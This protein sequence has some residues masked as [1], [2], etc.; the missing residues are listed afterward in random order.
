MIDLNGKRVLVTGGAGFVG[1]HLCE[2]LI[3]LGYVLSTGGTDNHLLLVNL[4]DKNITGNKVELICELV[5]I[6]LNKNAVLGDKSALTPG[7]IRIGT[8][9]LTTRG[10]LEKDFIE[11]ANLLD[12]TIKL[13]I[14]IQKKSGKKLIDFKKT[15]TEEY[16]NKEIN[17]IKKEVNT[18]AN[19]FEF[20]DDVVFLISSILSLLFFHYLDIFYLQLCA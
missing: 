5:E 12:K 13:T 9:A 11:V 4:R 6:S 20:I 18:L 14:D 19:K 2:R 3:E 16:Y 10:F 7:G 17:T 1:S 8:S 15:I